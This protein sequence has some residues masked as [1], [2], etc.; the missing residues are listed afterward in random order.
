MFN[1][2]KDIALSKGA[3]MAINSQIEAYGEVLELDLNSKDKSM[4]MKV[5]LDGELEPLSVQVRH[6]EFTQ[7]AGQHELSIS[8]VTTSRAW[9]NALAS[10]FLEGKTFP[11]SEKYAGML[12]KVL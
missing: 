1:K 5:L 8:G 3:K 11:I 12:K 10:E 2:V 9:I 6:Y 7:I 4:E